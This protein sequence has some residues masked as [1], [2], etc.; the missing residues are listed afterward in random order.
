MVTDTS[1]DNNEEGM[2]AQ[3]VRGDPSAYARLIVNWIEAIVVFSTGN[4]KQTDPNAF[5]RRLRDYQVEDVPIENIFKQ[6][7]PPCRIEI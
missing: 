2:L 3:L 5:R 4:L 1:N 7:F 6:K